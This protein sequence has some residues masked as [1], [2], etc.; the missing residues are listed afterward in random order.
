MYILRLQRLHW[1]VCIIVHNRYGVFMRRL[2][3]RGAVLT[4]IA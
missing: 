1:D 4:D 3:A 2:P